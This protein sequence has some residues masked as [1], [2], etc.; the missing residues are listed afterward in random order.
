M[1]THIRMGYN[2]HKGLCGSI[3]RFIYAEEVGMAFDGVELCEACQN[4]EEYVLYVLGRVGEQPPKLEAKL[5]G[6]QTGR[7]GITK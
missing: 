5:W 7:T 1:I 3:K 4:S 2:V 6:T